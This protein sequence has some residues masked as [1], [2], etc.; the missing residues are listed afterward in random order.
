MTEKQPNQQSDPQNYPPYYE[1]EINLIDYLRVLWKWKWLIIVGTL[2]CA[3]AA[4]G[5]TMVKY[6]AKD[7]TECAI[8]LNFPGIEEHKNPDGSLFSKDQIITPAILTKATAFLKKE[9]K[10]FSR[11]NVRGMTDIKAIIPPEIQEKIEKAKKAKKTY[12]FFPNQFRISLTL[13]RSDILSIKERN[14]ILLSIVDE[15]RKDF[16]KKYGEKPLVAV[17]FPTNFLENSDYLDAINTFKVRTN[18][19]IIDFHGNFLPVLTK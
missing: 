5:I 6:P 3:I 8:S 15:Y 14:R 4:M 10:S 7:V 11:E 13:E 9:N 16:E 17:K 12:S 18:N 2:I 1:D 19:F